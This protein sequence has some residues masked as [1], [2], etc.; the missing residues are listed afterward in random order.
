MVTG[1]DAG[2]LLDGRSADSVAAG[3]RRLLE[4]PP[5]RAATRAYAEGFGWDDTARGLQTM[6]QRV[7]GT[8]FWG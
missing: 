4:A 2:L 5:D 7:V 6:L 3:I 8:T 1:P